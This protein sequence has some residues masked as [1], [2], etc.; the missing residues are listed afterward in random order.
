MDFD[1]ILASGLNRALQTAGAVA[2]RQRRTRT[3]EAHPIFSEGGI[4]TAVG[5]KPFSEIRAVFPFAV[6]AAGA[7]T[8][9]NFIFSE[10]TS[11]DADGSISGTTYTYYVRYTMQNGEEVEAKLGSGKGIDNQIGGV[12][13]AKDLQEGSPVRIKYLPEKPKY[14]IRA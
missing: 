7:E 12:K 8:E 2:A 3:V 6:P 13:W 11:T 10:D 14:V 5:V 9:T 4:P 1:C